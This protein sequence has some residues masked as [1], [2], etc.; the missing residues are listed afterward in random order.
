VADTKEFSTE[1]AVEKAVEEAK[2]AAEEATEAEAEETTDKSED[3]KK[4]KKNK[5]EKKDKKDE[6][7]EQLTEQIDSMKDQVLRQMAEFT[8]FR[9][10]SEKEKSQMYDMGAKAIVEKVLPVVDNFERGL[11]GV[12]EGDD[13]FSD[14]ML[15]IYRQ[16]ITALKEVGVE[17]IEAVGTEFNPDL[18]NA[19][20]Q[21]ESDEVESGFVA[22]EL[23]KGYM[24]KDQVVRH[25]MVSV[26]Q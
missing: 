11:A 13:A 21:V 3:D 20:M 4:S 10:R 6:Q 24:Y 18:H 12:N 23:Q 5:K 25:S 26:A 14:G 8:N 7:I 17:P 1:E 2:A 9:N 16:M 22:A 15:M 19:V